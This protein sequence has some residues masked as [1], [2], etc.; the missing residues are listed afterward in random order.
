MD[1][2]RDQASSEIKSSIERFGQHIY[3][4]GIGPLPR[5]AY[6]IGLSEKS[7]GAEFILPGAI[8]LPITEVTQLLNDLSALAQSGDFDTSSSYALPN[9]GTVR[10]GSVHPTWTRRLLLGAADYYPDKSVSGLQVLLQ[11]EFNTIDTPDLAQEWDPDSAPAWRWLDLPWNY[12]IPK[13]TTVVTNLR[14]LRGEAITEVSHWEDD[15]WELMAA[16]ST[17][18]S[19]SDLHVIAFGTLLAVDPAL[20]D[21]LSLPLGSSMRRES[22]SSPWEPWG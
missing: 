3:V 4:V 9:V 7:V 18:I 8:T 2:A 14:A 22:H 17:P 5:F 15:E 10:L 1:D 13:E 6:T 11:D 20:E 16:D 12:P 21:V 19:E